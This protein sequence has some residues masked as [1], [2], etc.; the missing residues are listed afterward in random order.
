MCLQARVWAWGA[1][2]ASSLPSACVLAAKAPSPPHCTQCEAFHNYLLNVRTDAG[3]S[4]CEVYYLLFKCD[5]YEGKNIHVRA[6]IA[7]KHQHTLTLPLVSVIYHFQLSQ[8]CS[9]SWKNSWDIVL[10]FY[11]GCFP[12]V[13]ILQMMQA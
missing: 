11:P 3:S 7:Y 2:C 10:G 8:C 12:P 1:V 5:Y 4:Q 6:Q 9:I 13:P